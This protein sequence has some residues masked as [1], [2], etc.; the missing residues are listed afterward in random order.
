[1]YFPQSQIKTNLYTNGG[2]FV[3]L[4]TNENYK[5][6]YWST[7]SG[8]YYT[9]KNPQDIPYEELIKFSPPQLTDTTVTSI[10]GVQNTGSIEDLSPNY[11]EVL[12]Y[13]L[14]RGVD[15]NNPIVQNLPQYFLPTPTEEE[16]SL[17]A[18]TRYLCKRTN[19]N[20]YIEI[21]EDTFNGLKDASP[22]YLS[23]LYEPFSITWTLTGSTVSEVS[24]IN[25]D[26]VSQCEKQNKY[27]G[28][29]RYFKNYSQFFKPS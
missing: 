22:E 9:K 12:A 17:G 11:E 18:F 14:A 13:D 6:S 25:F 27:K 26:I 7:S 20:I 3:I 24:K 5:G 2:E 16:Y 19:Q 15:I 1:M 29:T 8:K 23:S 4:L 21:N 10:L 28:L